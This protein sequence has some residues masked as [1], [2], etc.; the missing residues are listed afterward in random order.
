MIVYRCSRTGL[1]FPANY[2]EEWGKTYGVGLGPVPVSEALVNDYHLPVVEQ[3][4]MPMHPVGYCGAA[5]HAIDVSQEEYDAHVAVLQIDDANMAL[6]AQIMRDRQLV[7]STRMKMLFGSQ[8]EEAQARI[9]AN[10]Y[11]Q[12]A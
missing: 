5:I 11:G 8:V 9:A 7:K 10:A 3:G 6:R 4:I 2:I 12:A 1:Y